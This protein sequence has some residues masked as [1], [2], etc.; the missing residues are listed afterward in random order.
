MVTA[1]DR[2][3]LIELLGEM[4]ERQPL[5]ID[6]LEQVP[7]KNGIRY[8]IRYF[9]EAGNPMIHTP[10][11][12]GS[13]FL[14]V[15]SLKNGKKA[16][17]IVAIHQ[18]D[19]NFHIGKAEPAGIMG[20]STM[21]YGK[22]L[23]ERGYVVIC[24]D[25]YYHADR[26]KICQD[27]G[28]FSQPDTERDMYSWLKRNGVLLSEGRNCWGKEAYDLSRAVDVLVS[29]PEVDADNIG[30]IGHS[31]GANVMSYFVFFD[32]RVKAS[33]ANCGTMEMNSYW[34]YNRPGGVFGSLAMPNS[35]KTGI[36]THDY[37]GKIAPR[38]FFIIQ[39]AHQWGDGQPDINDKATEKELEIFK[40]AYLNEGKGSSINTLFFEENKGRH[41]FPPEV[42]EQAYRWLDEHLKK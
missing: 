13:A 26:R 16:P 7:L 20:D 22:E 11:D 5:R 9:I 8:K 33:V 29:L 12:W 36:D 34:D 37:I 35:V 2:E 24:P 18:D 21:Y 4:P 10:D 1:H 28:D 25:R 39:G 14:F 38:A 41:S 19:V 23:F 40:N 31:A 32:T 30:A 42:K 15:P 6:T 17:A 27:W 3:A